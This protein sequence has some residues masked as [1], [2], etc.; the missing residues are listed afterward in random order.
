M[1]DFVRRVLS[2]GF[3]GVTVTA[4]AVCG[5]LRGADGVEVDP[6]AAA[7]SGQGTSAEG[8]LPVSKNGLMR[9]V[10][11]LDDLTN[12]NACGIASK[13]RYVYMAM[14]ESHEVIQVYDLADPARP[15][16]TGYI[17]AA[18]WPKEV[19]VFGRFGATF[20]PTRGN[21][22]SA[23]DFSDPAAPKVL[24]KDG[25]VAMLKTPRDKFP[26]RM[27]T[28]SEV[29][30]NLMFSPSKGGMQIWDIQDPSR[31]V[32]L[33]VAPAG[34]K[35]VIDGDRAYIGGGRA[36]VIYDIRDPKSPRRI[37]RFEMPDMGTKVG[38]ISPAAAK[39][40]FL[41]LLTGGGDTVLQAND[42]PTPGALSG[43]A[44]VDARK[45]ADAKLVAASFLEGFIA[46]YRDATLVSTGRGKKT[47]AVADPSFG[48]RV[49]DVSKPARPR[50][51]AGDRRGGEC[52]A[53]AV[54]G[55][56]VYV[57]QNLSGGV[58]IVD[59]SNRRAPKTLSYLHTA[60]E[61]WGDIVPVGDGY[62]YFC[63]HARTGRGFWGGL[64]VAD[65]RNPRRPKLVARVPGIDSY[66]LVA[67]G[68][69]VYAGTGRIIDASQPEKPTVLKARLPV[70]GDGKAMAIVGKR[71][72]FC[73]P[74]GAHFAIIDITRP[75]QPK[76]LG[77]CTLWKGMHRMNQIAV[78]GDKVVL[79]GG[80]NAEGHG[81]TIKKLGLKTP[82]P[83]DKDPF[84]KLTVID[85]SD[86]TKP[87]LLKTW[88]LD[89]L[90]FPRGWDDRL[91]SVYIHR[92]RLF[93][94]QY[95]G[96]IRAYD[97]ASLPNTPSL[98]D[99]I[100]VNYWTWLTAGDGK[101]LYCVKLMGLDVIEL[102]Q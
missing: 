51:I 53:V 86:E 50:P 34:G 16:K 45:P 33:G 37:G 19:K 24:K 1:D 28:D 94:S 4:L 84:T 17:P 44:V 66:G 56:T 60:M 78:F 81:P 64:H 58:W 39:D 71:L 47:L 13:G 59:V 95:S 87:K 67:S 48:L 96:R 35:F 10:G 68:R 93:V 40:G 3:L 99:E 31:P 27:L 46:G 23:V 80:T 21:A 36:V 85:I 2:L 26:C 61:I 5:V 25:G 74:G 18:G 49:Y 101:Y 91:N 22:M 73:N 102:S 62:I 79:S 63:G 55:D 52:S 65:V 9:V 92:G 30:G 20:S 88:T 54:K 89:Q 7:R 57:G 69:Y 77:E 83:P 100:R 15:K 41:Y 97:W 12:G 38:G 98:Q 82:I 70:R 29:R 6:D 14:N 72:Y 42:R 90:G 43:I 11:R 75:E 8:S 32:A 76:L